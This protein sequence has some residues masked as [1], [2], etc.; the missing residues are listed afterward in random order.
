[1]NAFIEVNANILLPAALIL[2]VVAVTAVILLA[3]RIRRMQ[4]PFSEMAGLYDDV[5]TEDSL[6]LLLKGVD[7]NREFIKGHGEDLRLIHESLEECFKGIG[8][9]K[10]NAFE[11]VGGNQS[12]S[13]CILTRQKN[14]FMLTNLVGRNST[15]GYAIEVKS[16]AAEREL[17]SEETEALAYAVKSLEE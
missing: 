15:R 3:A 6:Q 4:R 11:D 12:Y 14:G 16:G 13:I 5:G 17:G 9:V 7:E 2:S 8:M 10:Y 1:M